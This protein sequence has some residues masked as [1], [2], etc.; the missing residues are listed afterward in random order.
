MSAT[1]AVGF[2]GVDQ[3]NPG[4]LRSSYVCARRFCSGVRDHSP[5]HRRPEP[6]Q[7]APRLPLGIGCLQCLDRLGGRRSLAPG[8]CKLGLQPRAR[9]L[10]LG[11]QSLD[12]LAQGD[13]SPDISGGGSPD[14]K[15]AGARDVIIAALASPVSAEHQPLGAGLADPAGF[16]Q[17]LIAHPPAVA[18]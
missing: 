1:V 14:R 17:F 13:A 18:R 8:G 10:D 12:P 4:S 11:G 7:Q 16:G 2:A 3:E 9:H 15:S 5:P 6:R